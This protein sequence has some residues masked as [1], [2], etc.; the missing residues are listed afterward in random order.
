MGRLCSEALYKMTKIFHPVGPV[1]VGPVDKTRGYEGKCFRKSRNV[2][3]N[4]D[5]SKVL[6]K[7]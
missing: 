6:K 3:K 7:C 5:R 1:R 2:F 4:I